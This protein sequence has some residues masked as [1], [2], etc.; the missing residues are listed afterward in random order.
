MSAPSRE[1]F[2]DHPRP[3]EAAAAIFCCV[4][5]PRCLNRHAATI[6]TG[7]DWTD[8]D[9]ALGFEA[10]CKAGGERALATAIRSAPLSGWIV[11]DVLGVQ[12]AYCPEHADRG[13]AQRRRGFA[14]WG[15]DVD[16]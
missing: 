5:D 13:L 9:L 15:Q 6:D 2:D 8:P 1:G 11:L 10:T 16:R 14:L 12:M 7:R 3:V 4:R